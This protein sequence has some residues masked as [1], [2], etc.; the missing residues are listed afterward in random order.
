MRGLDILKQAGT[1][2]LGEIDSS[3]PRAS[4]SN[5]DLI[6]D[7]TESSAETMGQGYSDTSRTAAPEMMEESGAGGVGSD[8]LNSFDNAIDEINKSSLSYKLKPFELRQQK[9]KRE[10]LSLQKK[11]ASGEMTQEEAEKRIAE[12]QSEL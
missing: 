5:M 2:G 6:R 7:I 11:V 4:D 12:Q 10:I 8:M 3:S 9:A 1:T